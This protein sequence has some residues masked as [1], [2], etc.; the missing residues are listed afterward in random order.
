MLLCFPGVRNVAVCPG[1]VV[2]FHLEDPGSHEGD[3]VTSWHWQ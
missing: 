2:C 1:L 3:R